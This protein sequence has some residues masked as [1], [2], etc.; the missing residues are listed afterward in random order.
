MDIS[1]RSK[2]VGKSNSIETDND[3]EDSEEN[4]NDYNLNDSNLST[5]PLHSHSWNYRAT[6]LVG[7]NG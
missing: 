6:T 2:V 7:P 5:K 1:S 4:I 3:E